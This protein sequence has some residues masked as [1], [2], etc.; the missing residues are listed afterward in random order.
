M[1]RPPTELMT[2]ATASARFIWISPS[3]VRQ[4]ATM[5]RGKRI[6]EARRI[7][8]FTPKAGSRHL[9]KVLESA[10]ANA[11]HNFQ[12]PQE[13]LFVKSAWADEGPVRRKIRPRARRAADIQLKRMSHIHVV[14]ERTEEPQAAAEPTQKRR[15]ARRRR[16]RRTED[17]DDEKGD[18]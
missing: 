1:A 17:K 12:I 6:D 7:L 5:I 15:P 13:E 10:I 8:A 11:E 14:V 4:V 3:K 9:A 16:N 2:Q 18:E